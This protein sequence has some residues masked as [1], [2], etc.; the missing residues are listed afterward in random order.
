MKPSPIIL[1]I[2][3]CSFLPHIDFAT[4]FSIQLHIFSYFSNFVLS[5]NLLF[6]NPIKISWM[7]GHMPLSYS[8]LFSTLFSR[9]NMP[10]FTFV[11]CNC[12]RAISLKELEL[13]SYVICL[14]LLLQIYL[15]FISNKRC[16]IQKHCSSLAQHSN[17]TSSLYLIFLFFSFG[18]D[19]IV[20]SP[21]PRNA[22][23]GDQHV[24]LLYIS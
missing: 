2:Y 4:Q 6:L 9:E 20:I 19:F 13:V 5:S 16:S 11:E 12:L 18:S 22:S 17:V 24:P 7:L 23:L 15:Y 10:L 21:I 3:W 14:E 8:V 1:S